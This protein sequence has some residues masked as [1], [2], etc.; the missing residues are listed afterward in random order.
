[1]SL[2]AWGCTPPPSDATPAPSSAA[3]DSGAETGEASEG[4]S[5]DDGPALDLP[6]EDPEDEPKPPSDLCR[7][8]DPNVSTDPQSIE[9]TIELINAL[10]K[11]LSLACFIESLDRPLRLDATDSI[12]SAQPADG[13]EDPRLFILRDNFILSIVTDGPGQALLEFGEFI[14]DR[15]TLKGELEFPID[16]TLTFA[17]AFDRLPFDDGDSSVCGF[18][19]GGEYRSDEYAGGYISDAFRPAYWT[20][21]DFDAVRDEWK[22]CDPS[23]E[24]ERC[25]LFEAVFGRGEVEDAA[26]PEDLPP[27]FE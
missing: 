13:P 23:L 24:P 20:D 5:E 21:V 19:H 15:Q 4:E 14:T 2:W 18:C 3:E 17:S 1:M 8:L 10:P 7:P 25:A 6:E 27:F 26:F 12:F 22:A 16:T 11:P 9:E